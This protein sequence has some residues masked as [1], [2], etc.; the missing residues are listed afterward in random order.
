MTNV[1]VVGERITLL[2]QGGGEVTTGIVE[3][4]D[5]MRTLLRSDEG[6]PVA[7]PNSAVMNYI[8]INRSRLQP[9]KEIFRVRRFNCACVLHR[10]QNLTCYLANAY[11]LSLI[12]WFPVSVCVLK[13]VCACIVAVRCRCRPGV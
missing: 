11:M 2:G 5:P 12:H 10:S 9:V 4:I 3:R 6:L 7:L 13:R 8:V 1:F